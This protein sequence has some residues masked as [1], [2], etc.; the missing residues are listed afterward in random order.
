VSYNS[1]TAYA[2]V[3]RRVF[4]PVHNFTHTHTHTNTQFAKVNA[5]LHLRDGRTDEET[6]L[7]RPSAHPSVRVL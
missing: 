2:K 3:V 1:E 6:R 4:R 7:F 5:K